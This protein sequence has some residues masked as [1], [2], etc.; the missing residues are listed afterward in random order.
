MDPICSV[1]LGTGLLGGCA[2][3]RRHDVFVKIGFEIL[4]FVCLNV[5]VYI[6]K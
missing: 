1:R 3:L 6:A 4:N 5:G 2:L